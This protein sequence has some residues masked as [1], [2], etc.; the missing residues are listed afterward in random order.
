MLPMCEICSAPK[1]KIRY[2]PSHP[3]VAP[4]AEPTSLTLPSAGSHPS[5]NDSAAVKKPDPPQDKKSEEAGAC[6][7]PAR[8][9][10]YQS[11][12]N[13]QSSSS[14][15]RPSSRPPSAQGRANANGGNA[16]PKNNKNNKQKQALYS[17][18]TEKIKLK[19]GA[20]AA[21]SIPPM[22]VN[23]EDSDDEDPTPVNPV[24]P[25]NLEISYKPQP[26][27]RPPDTPSRINNWLNSDPAPAAA[28]VRIVP[29][30]PEPLPMP[31][32][33]PDKQIDS[34]SS[35]RKAERPS[36]EDES[37]ELSSGALAQDQ[38]LDDLSITCDQLPLSLSSHSSPSHKQLA[39]NNLHHLNT[40]GLFEQASNNF[41]STGG[42]EK[43]KLSG[44][45][46]GKPKK[47]SNVDSAS[48]LNKNSTEVLLEKYEHNEEEE[49]DV[50]STG[51]T[52][53]LKSSLSVINN[54]PRAASASSLVSSAKFLSSNRISRGNEL[55]RTVAE[56]NQGQGALNSSSLPLQPSHVVGSDSARHLQHIGR[57]RSGN[58]S[59][60]G[61]GGRENTFPPS[62]QLGGGAGGNKPLLN[63][64]SRRL[65]EAFR[66]GHVISNPNNPSSIT[67][68]STSRNNNEKDRLSER[69]RPRRRSSHSL[70][71]S[72]ERER[73]VGKGSVNGIGPRSISDSGV[74]LENQQ[75]KR[76]REARLKKDEQTERE[77]QRQRDL[78]RIRA[79]DRL[80]PSGISL[81]SP[82]SSVL[83]MSLIYIYIYI[84]FLS[85]C[86]FITA[87]DDPDESYSFLNNSLSTSFGYAG[88]RADTVLIYHSFLCSLLSLFLFML[89]IYIH[90]NKILFFKTS[91][92]EFCMCY[93]VLY[94]YIYHISCLGSGGS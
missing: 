3:A 49:L 69:D 40:S 79:Q 30:T 22:S 57:R 82:R 65:P 87:V 1:P 48:I 15:S 2:S 91:F 93:P 67:N 58:G 88:E 74:G 92:L 41:D 56:K 21:H 90:V 83:Y 63:L 47:H 6:Q 24:S 46:G 72:G 34:D 44:S 85:Q 86:V 11:K 5:N 33:E 54:S 77:R 60:N 42:S 75:F 51:L 78:D 29:Q 14:S 45:G 37:L 52:A 73:G 19:F 25:Q 35:E 4:S 59:K 8:P 55:L 70:N 71:N 10:S 31:G 28:V 81:T 27:E 50:G 53:D 61:T 43:L 94:T 84:C 68:P 20:P 76:E 64:S 62:K 13:K 17:K 9:F 66:L 16:N 18:I 23:V 39:H 38:G 7:A 26:P 32:V 80:A 89:Y 36:G 12:H